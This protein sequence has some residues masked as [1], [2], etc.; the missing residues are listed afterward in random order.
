[1]KTVLIV[2]C[3]SLFT[4]GSFDSKAREKNNPIPVAQV[5]RTLGLSVESSKGRYTKNDQFKLRVM[6]TNLGERDIYIFGTFDWGYSSSLV[7]HIRD[8]SGKEV[9]PLLSPDS[10]TYASAAD[11]SAFVKLGPDHFL[12]TTY[13]AP[14]SGPFVP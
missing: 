6:L 7:F 10:Q 2:A 4:F 12:G 5:V 11:T 3:A 9:Q 8:A 14:M 13:Y 1:M